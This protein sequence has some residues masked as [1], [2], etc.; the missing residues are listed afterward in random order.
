MQF[1]TNEVKQKM[2]KKSDISLDDFKKWIEE[3]S[4]QDCKIEE[5]LDNQGD[6]YN[7]RE[8]V[9]KISLKKIHSKAEVDEG[10]TE[11]VC[12]DFYE[13]GGK[14]IDTVDGS[15]LI[16]VESGLLYIKKSYVEER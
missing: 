15:F 2:I 7:G 3:E 5:D 11:E 12:L 10:Y 8:V 14:I 6:D 13:N 1:Q 9:S 4:K 16:E